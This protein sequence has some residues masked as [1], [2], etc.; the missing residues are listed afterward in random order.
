MKSLVLSIACALAAGAAQAATFTTHIWE[1]GSDVLVA[2][3]G[4]LD[5]TGY[6]VTNTFVAISRIRSYDSVLIAGATNVNS[7]SIAISGPTLGTGTFA[8]ATS[9]TGDSVGIW[10]VGGVVYAPVG[11]VSGSH[12]AN[13]S[14]FANR[15]LAGL[16]LTAGTYHYAF[17]TNTYTVEVGTSPVPEAATLPMLLAGLLGLG[18]MRRREARASNPNE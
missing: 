18:L 16:G 3:E 11:Y 1:S 4:A 6:A 13:T 10:G 5:L 9:S 17:G 7:R 8:A 15:T 14:T 12:L 2:G